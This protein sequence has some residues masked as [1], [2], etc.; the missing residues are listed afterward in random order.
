MAALEAAIPVF[1][2]RSCANKRMEATAIGLETIALLA[3]KRLEQ[4]GHGLGEPLRTAR[5]IDQH[6]GHL[7]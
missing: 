7:G 4:L 1:P 5:R 3:S 2:K 6:H